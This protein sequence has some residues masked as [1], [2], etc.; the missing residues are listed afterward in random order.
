MH[1]LMKKTLTVLHELVSEHPDFA[2]VHEP[3]NNE[4]CFRYVPNS[5]VEHQEEPEI[6]ARLNELNDQ[7]VSA[8]I[9]GG[10]ARVMT[11]SIGGF[12]AI[13]ITLPPNE[14]QTEDVEAVFEAIARWGH[15]LNKKLPGHHKPEM[16]T[17]LC[18]SELHS[19][20][21]EVSAT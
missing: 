15:L 3:T 14:T 19:L 16:E 13:R 1:R 11:T 21:T 7:I 6:Q 9:N 4:Y 12:R 10:F 5:L 17:E 18:S 2:V 8:I 20:L